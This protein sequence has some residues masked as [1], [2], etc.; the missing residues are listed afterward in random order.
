M[1]VLRQYLS[2]IEGPTAAVRSFAIR[3]GLLLSLVVLFAS[4]CGC[5]SNPKAVRSSLVPYTIEQLVARDKAKEARYQIRVG[6]S[7]KLSFKYEKDLDE[8][9]ILVLPDGY[10]SLPGIGSVKA[11]GRTIPELDQTLNDL[12]GR[13]YRNPDLTLAVTEISDPE[14]YVLGNV[15]RPGIYKVPSNGLGV[16]QAVAL[17]GGFTRSAKKSN[18]VVMRATEEGFVVHTFDLGH[19]EK[20]GIRG[21]PYLDLRPYDIIYVPQSKLGDFTY[22]TESIFGSTLDVTRFFWDVYALANI[23]KIDRLVR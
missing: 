1:T 16:M 2:A 7:L 23:D 10:I 22:L 9:L 5:A 12:Y 3:H 13:E 19:I 4:L 17:A 18:T 11:V 6:D 14:V 8:D 20:D 15:E 21:L